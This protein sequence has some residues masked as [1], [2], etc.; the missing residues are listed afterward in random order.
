MQARRQARR[1]LFE[2]GYYSRA[3]SDRGYTVA[4]LDPFTALKPAVLQ[5]FFWRPKQR[6]GCPDLVSG[7]SLV[8]L[9]SSF[10]VVGAF[11]PF[12]GFFMAVIEAIDSVHS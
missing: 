6:M 8:P 10:L 2:G 3:A 12:G 1:P 11:V 5:H 7:V 9:P 4:F